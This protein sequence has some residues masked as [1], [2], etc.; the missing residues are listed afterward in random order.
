MLVHLVAREFTRKVDDYSKPKTTTRIRKGSGQDAKR[1]M[2]AT[3]ER[4]GYP[5]RALPK[6]T[7][8][9]KNRIRADLAAAAFDEPQDDPE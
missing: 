2:V 9:D 7:F 6:Y 4:W 5:A 8:L 3:L 1:R